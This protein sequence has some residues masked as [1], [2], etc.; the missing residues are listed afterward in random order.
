MSRKLLLAHLVMLSVAILYS[1]NFFVIRDAFRGGIPPQAMLA[2][3][4]L[5][6]AAV[7]MVL[8]RVFIREKVARADWPRLI[9]CALTG[10][11]T[12]QWLFLEGMSR[13]VEINGAVLMITTPLF[14]FLIAWLARQETFTPR[15]ILGLCLAFGGSFWLVSGG[16]NLHFSRETA[17]GDVMVLFNALSYGAYLVL[18]KPLAARYQS[19]TIVA[20]MFTL[21]LV[22]TLPVGFTA[23]T[24]VAWATLSGGTWAALAF[25]LV[26]ATVLAYGLNAWAMSHV[27]ASYVG[28]YVYLQPPLVAI[29]TFVLG[30]GE[31]PW[32]KLVCIAAVITGVFLATWRKP[33][34]I[35]RTLRMLN[36]GLYRLRYH[37]LFGRLKKAKV[38]SS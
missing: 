17:L 2:L 16:G 6:G 15:R 29:L 37:K 20:W 38:Y 19:S 4:G 9:L 23:A 7:F 21:G 18:V 10:I 5:G 25:V 11:V 26:G 1:I 33:I 14:V 28:L 13:T 24:Q 30:R 32:W 27:P 34:D 36:V 12:N 31:I 22:V 8:Q 35:Q 3:R